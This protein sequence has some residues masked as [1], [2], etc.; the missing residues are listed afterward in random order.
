MTQETFDYWKADFEAFEAELAKNVEESK[1]KEM[2]DLK[3]VADYLIVY[4]MTGNQELV[5]PKS[6]YLHKT[7]GGKY[8]FGPV[9]DFDWSFG[10]YPGYSYFYFEPA[11]VKEII[12]SSLPG[13]L[14][15]GRMLSDPEFISIYKDRWEYFKTYCYPQL[16]DYIERYDALILESVGRDSQIF[17]NTKK[18]AETVSAMKTWLNS[19]INYIDNE[20][21]TL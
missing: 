11:V 21:K 19:R 16:K 12:T 10:Y 9:W 20:A 8:T 5:H 2:V 14:F 4:N 17:D 6:V 7:K 1:Y 18:H 13:G 15:L 3:S